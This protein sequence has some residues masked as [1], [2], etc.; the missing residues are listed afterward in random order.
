VVRTFW[1]L[2]LTAYRLTGGGFGLS[3]PVAGLRDR[4]NQHGAEWAAGN[5]V[6]PWLRV[7]IAARAGSA[8][9][10]AIDADLVQ[11]DVADA[12]QGRMVG[13]TGFEPVTSRM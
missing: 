2:H 7:I 3:R 11:E 8:A 9:A 13:D 6:D 5:V 12:I 1:L 4:A 10:I